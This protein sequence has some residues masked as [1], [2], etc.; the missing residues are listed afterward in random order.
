MIRRLVLLVVLGLGLVGDADA[1][2]RK[3]ILPTYTGTN[4]NSGF[5]TADT[6]YCWT[7]VA[8]GSLTATKFAAYLAS[9]NPTATASFALFPDNDAAAALASVTGPAIGGSFGQSGLTPFS[10]VAGTLYRVCG[11]GSVGSSGIKYLGVE[12]ATACCQD[13]NLTQLVQTF[14]ATYVGTAAN[15]CTSGTLPG[16]TGAITADATSPG[17]NA[18]RIPVT[19]AEE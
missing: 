5:V 16:T 7:I 13:F 17:R 19:I 8:P 15:S 2:N 1:G 14:H 10:L 12:Q 11:C 18:P 9:N 6:L 3:L 4:G